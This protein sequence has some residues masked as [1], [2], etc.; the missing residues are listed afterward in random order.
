MAVGIGSI[1]GLE[2]AGP[3][4]KSELVP[5]RKDPEPD[6]LPPVL[7]AQRHARDRPGILL[8]I[9]PLDGKARAL[10]DSG[11]GKTVGRFFGAGGSIFRSCVRRGR[12]GLSGA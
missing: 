4:P 6:E 11:R 8:E 7:V 1:F 2:A 3:F 10:P 12:G 5:A 9:D